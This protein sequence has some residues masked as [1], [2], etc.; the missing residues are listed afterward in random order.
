MRR[1]LC[2]SEAAALHVPVGT[3]AGDGEGAALVPVGTEAGDGEGAALVPV[4]WRQETERMQLL[5]L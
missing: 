2:E 5:L 3:E 4:S 1:L